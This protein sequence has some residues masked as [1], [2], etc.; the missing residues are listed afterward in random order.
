[1]TRKFKHQ[2]GPEEFDE[3]P[4]GRADQL[5]LAR[6]D[7]LRFGMVVLSGPLLLDFLSNLGP[8]FLVQE[9]KGKRIYI[10][11]DDHTDLF[12]TA[13]L[14]TYEKVFVETL[15]Y[16]L[17]L[18]DKTAKEPAEF[19]SRWNCDGNFWIWTYERKK[20]Q[21]DFM[22]LIERIRDGHISIPLNALCVCLGG[23]PA[24]AVLRG[25]YYAGKLERRHALRLNLAYSMENQTLPF[26]LGAL[27]S[28]S[29]ATFSWKGIL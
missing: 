29:G 26:G 19:Q 1:M 13:D 27:W 28:G 8:D 10:A 6:R 12:W 5:F 3:S 7:F 16:Y 24:E 18:A 22:R 23:A 17:D 14:E 4:A 20:P 11:P 15:D 9:F 25:M 21:A 2:A